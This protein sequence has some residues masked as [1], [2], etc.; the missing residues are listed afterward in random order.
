[1]ATTA[2]AVQ[3]SAII[4]T[5]TVDDL[6]KS[7]AFYEAL[8][9][10][11]DERWE[12]NGTLLGVMLRAGKSLA[13]G[14][15]GAGVGVLADRDEVVAEPRAHD[16]LDEP[17]GRGREARLVELVFGEDDLAVRARDGLHPADTLDGEQRLGDLVDDDEVDTE[18]QK[19]RSK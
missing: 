19:L 10:V 8:G 9:F 2:D 6:Q 18:T 4:P 14:E 12:E 3:I 13:F 5:L 1:M 16:A 17:E 11:I 7:I 15:I